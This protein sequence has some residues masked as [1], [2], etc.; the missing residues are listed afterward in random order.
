MILEFLPINLHRVDVSIMKH[1]IYH[2]H[3][4]KTKEVLPKYVTYRPIA[5]KSSFTFT[6][7]SILLCCLFAYLDFAWALHSK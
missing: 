7:R 1:S 5:I 4:H 3:L 2:N 6:Q